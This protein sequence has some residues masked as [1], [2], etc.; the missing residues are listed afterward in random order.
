MC[1]RLRIDRRAHFELESL[2]RAYIVHLLERGLGSADF[3]DALR[4][5]ATRLDAGG[6]TGV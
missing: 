1:R 2:L 5:Q 4:R 3:M 6:V